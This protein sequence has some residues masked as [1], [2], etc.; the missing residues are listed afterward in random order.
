MA[1]RFTSG[2]LVIPNENLDV[3][4]KSNAFVFL[5]YPHVMMFFECVDW[6]IVEFV[7]IGVLQED[8]VDGKMKSSKTAPKKG[9]LGFGGRKALNDITNKSSFHHEAFSRKNNFRKEEIN[10]AEEKFLHDHKKCIEAQQKTVDTFYL[11][12]VLPG[13]GSVCT[14]DPQESKETENDLE[15]PR[16][17]PEPA[18][19]P[20]SEFADWLS[21]PTEWTSPPCSPIHGDLPSVSTFPWESELVEF[22][23]KQECD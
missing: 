8:G 10:V 7:K 16:C 9:G 1:T 11:D 14:G 18:E 22:T 13:R 21:S 23:L 2:Q 5:L 3:H 15:S 6:N 4:R 19:L 20:M 12:L 17:Y